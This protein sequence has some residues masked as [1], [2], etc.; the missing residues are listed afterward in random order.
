MSPQKQQP[1]QQTVCFSLR[2][3][4]SI[5][6]QYLEFPEKCHC[7]RRV[8]L[9]KLGIARYG[10]HQYIDE[11]HRKDHQQSDR[12]NS[13]LPTYDLRSMGCILYHCLF[14]SPLYNFDCQQINSLILF[15]YTIASISLQCL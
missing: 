3:V 1:W 11:P 6:K 5:Y 2:I 10:L 4:Y 8:A 7:G 13:G 15:L 12:K 9:H 14:G